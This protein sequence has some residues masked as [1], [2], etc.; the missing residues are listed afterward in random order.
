MAEPAVLAWGVRVAGIQLDTV[1]EN[2][3]ASFRRVVPLAERAVADGARL[4]VLPETFA[5]GLSQRA[6]A[7]AA[8]AP[9]VR[10]FLGDLARR[11]GAWL[12]GGLVEPGDRLPANA[13]LLV[14][15]SG[16]EV[17]RG[18][19]IHPF[20]LVGEAERYEPGDEIRTTTVEGVRVTPLICYDLRFVELF[21]A[22]AER[23]DCFVVLASWPEPR[24]HA[25]RTLLAA[26]AID[27]QA[28]VLGVN[29]VGE[30]EGRPHLGD[31]ALLDPL[32]EPVASLAGREGVVAG[33]VDPARVAELRARYPFLR[34]RRPGLY[35]RLGGHG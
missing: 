7:M 17:L 26:R 25:W 2:P 22:S 23:T 6:E 21:R 11:L 35:R 32:G 1:W 3:E 29:R 27:C 31:T 18:R 9:A 30:A 20:S 4:L 10:V 34:D 5:T 16:A 24:A 15:P 28:F 14:D 12:L 33:E 8:H 19:K 13:Y